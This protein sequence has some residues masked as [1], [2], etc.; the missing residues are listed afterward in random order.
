MCH[1]Y[2]DDQRM[3]RQSLPQPCYAAHFSQSL[4]CTVD[5]G[6][7]ICHLEPRMQIGKSSG[8]TYLDMSILRIRI[9]PICMVATIED[10]VPE[11]YSDKHGSWFQ[12]Q[13]VRGYDLVL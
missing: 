4:K 6:L 11:V 1:Q 5:S 7:I 3:P 13:C 12:K 2:L 8:M 9:G 10:V